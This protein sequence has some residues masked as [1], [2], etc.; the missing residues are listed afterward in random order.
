MGTENYN[1]SSMENFLKHLPSWQ[2]EYMTA[3]IR[4]AVFRDPVCARSPGHLNSNQ[5]A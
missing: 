2:L 4:A 1:T 5:K 3:I